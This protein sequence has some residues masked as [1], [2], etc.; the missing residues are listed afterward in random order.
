MEF[1]GTHAT[2]ETGPRLGQGGMAEVYLGNPVGQP[3][4]VV[5]NEL[6]SR[7]HRVSNSIIHLFGIASD[8]LRDEFYLIHK[9]LIVT[10]LVTLH[11]EIRFRLRHRPRWGTKVAHQRFLYLTGF[12]SFVKV[13][14]GLVQLRN[15]RYPQRS[16]GPRKREALTL[17]QERVAP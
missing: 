7:L 3:E 11:F 6:D 14:A 4:D 10:H 8:L 2:Y 13:P 17:A 5:L 1:R 9:R 12:A 15:H 16:Y